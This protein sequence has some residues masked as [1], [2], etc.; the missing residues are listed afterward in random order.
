MSAT[1]GVDAKESNVFTIDQSNA[2]S[3]P[4]VIN[5]N[6]TINVASTTQI[7]QTPK[8]CSTYQGRDFATIKQTALGSEQYSPLCSVKTKNGS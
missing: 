5:F 4:L 6:N 8:A 1:L 2:I 3:T 7:T